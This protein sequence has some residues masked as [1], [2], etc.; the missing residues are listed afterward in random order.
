MKEN[1]YN[2]SGTDKILQI[3]EKIEKISSQKIYLFA[4]LLDK[5]SKLRNYFEK[6]NNLGVL[7][8]Y[9]DTE[10]TLKNLLVE[11]LNGL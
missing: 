8:C 9:P 3:I 1:F 4:N 5:R 11:K 2:L 6:S 10:L 7:P